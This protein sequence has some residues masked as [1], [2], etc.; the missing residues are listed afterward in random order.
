MQQTDSCFT[1]Q[2]KSPISVKE[3]GNL[4]VFSLRLYLPSPEEGLVLHL[5]IEDLNEI[6]SKKN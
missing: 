2:K 1:G 6:L 3:L 4:Q 5:S